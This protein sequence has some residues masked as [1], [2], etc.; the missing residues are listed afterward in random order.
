MV[1]TPFLPEINH[2]FEETG[3]ASEKLPSEL[4]LHVL[5]C[6]VCSL[7]NSHTSSLAIPAPPKIFLPQ[8]LILH[9][10]PFEKEGSSPRHLND[11]SSARSSLSL[12]IG[13]STSPHSY[14]TLLFISH[15]F[16]SSWT[17]APLIIK[18]LIHHCIPNI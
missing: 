10:W 16:L 13:P 8:K 7:H 15:L 12:D 1:L 4:R 5:I 3:N 17:A 14:P 2:L 6:P 11:T 18:I 9:Y